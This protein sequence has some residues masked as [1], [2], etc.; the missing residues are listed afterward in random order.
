MY[1]SLGSIESRYC[2]G[3]ENLYRAYSANGSRHI[4]TNWYGDALTDC[5]CI[6]THYNLSTEI[7]VAVVAVL[8]PSIRWHSNLDAACQCIAAFR[9]GSHPDNTKLSGWPAN[10][11]KAFAIL[12]KADP[13]LLSGRKVC[14]FASNILG[15]ESTVTVD[16]HMIHLYLYGANG[17]PSGKLTVG[18]SAYGLIASAISE[19]ANQIGIEPTRFQSIVWQAQAARKA[20]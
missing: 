20:F 19:C 5:Q 11:R 17:E 3:V 6:A 10:K 8:S 12:A 13:S 18:K 15:C 4:K 1:I 2:V 16:R 9:S 7:V 14:A